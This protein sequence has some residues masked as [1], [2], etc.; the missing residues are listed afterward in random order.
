TGSGAAFRGGLAAMDNN[1][2]PNMAQ[3]IE[4]AADENGKT[5][6]EF[7][8]H[9]F[10]RG[11]SAN[12]GPEIQLHAYAMIEGTE[13]PQEAWEWLKFLSLDEESQISS[14]R[15]SGLVPALRPATQQ[16]FQERSN[17]NPSI[18]VFL[19]YFLNDATA[20]MRP[21]GWAPAGTII[22]QWVG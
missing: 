21:M 6:F 18:N 3:L 10:P 13:H 12:T 2:G 5:P 1:A 15:Y 17:E 20:Y 19:N 14:S 8:W 7:A 22:Q 4:A 9:P 16:Y 11:P